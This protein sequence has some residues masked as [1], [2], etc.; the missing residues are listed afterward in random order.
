MIIG[1]AGVVCAFAIWESAW[2]KIV[3]LVLFSPVLG[4]GIVI[5]ALN[6]ADV[7]GADS[8]G[9]PTA[10]DE[11]REA[12]GIDHIETVSGASLTSSI[13]N[14]NGR[15]AVAVTFTTDE[16]ESYDEAR[17][18]YDIVDEDAPAGEVTHRV[19]IEVAD[20]PGTEWV[21]LEPGGGAVMRPGLALTIGVPL[22]GIL[23]AVAVF[24]WTDSWGWVALL[25]MSTVGSLPL[26]L[27]RRARRA[28]RGES[29]ESG[30]S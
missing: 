1:L 21:P 23:G 12:Y 29:D 14:P 18:V 19:G 16:G 10:V 30:E 5:L 3:T 26:I 4:G 13:E 8:G 2:M 11:L 17:L 7:W 27:G 28:R 20:E 15:S 25:Y 22:V 6:F 9:G 24:L